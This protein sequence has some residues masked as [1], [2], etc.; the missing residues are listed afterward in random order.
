M[1]LKGDNESIDDGSANTQPAGKFRD[2]QTLAGI[3]NLFEDSYAPVQ[4]L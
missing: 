3:G 4:S 1:L 2:C